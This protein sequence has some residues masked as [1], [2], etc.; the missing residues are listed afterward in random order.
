M[1]W[2]AKN[3]FDLL[4]RSDLEL[5]MQHFQ[6]IPVIEAYFLGRMRK[7]IKYYNGVYI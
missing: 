4:Y 6:G 3:L 1:Y 7:L 2:G 5:N